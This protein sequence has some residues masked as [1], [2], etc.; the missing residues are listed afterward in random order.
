MDKPNNIPDEDF[1][2]ELSPMLQKLKKENPL[3]VP[4][5]YFNHL[6]ETI[7][8]RIEKLDNQPVKKYAFFSNKLYPVLAVAAMIGL[9]AFLYFM[10]IPSKNSHNPEKFADNSSGFNAIE[11]YLINNAG[12]D[13]ES[14]VSALI[15]ENDIT[16][17]L[18]AGDSLLINND[19][20]P[21]KGNTV[22][23]LSDTSISK[24]DILQY[25][26]EEDIEIEPDL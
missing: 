2:K 5:D 8:Q 1:S 20:I 12:I 4:D 19:S 23:F 6:P 15:E 7:K 21:Q 26:L 13:E 14:I 18:I 22:V 11:D 9:I 16:P 17:V 24:E 10:L 3:L 25:L